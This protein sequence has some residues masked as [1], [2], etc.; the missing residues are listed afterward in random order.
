M[1]LVNKTTSS[2]EL[3]KSRQQRIFGIIDFFNKKNQLSYPEAYLFTNHKIIHRQVHYIVLV[4]KE[5]QHMKKIYNE[6]LRAV[7]GYD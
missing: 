7:I 1:H 6:K 2:K 4:V 3:T 5:N